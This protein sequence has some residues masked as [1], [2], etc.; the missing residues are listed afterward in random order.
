MWLFCEQAESAEIEAKYQKKEMRFAIDG[1]KYT[2]SLS[3]MTQANR[4]TGRVR[5]IRRRPKSSSAQL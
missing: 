3:K 1:L 2:I 5:L 4:I